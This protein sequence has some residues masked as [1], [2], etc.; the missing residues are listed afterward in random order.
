MSA[1]V[2]TID[3]TSLEE[4]LGGAV[5]LPN[6]GS[7]DKAREIWNA[8][9][10]R[11][12]QAIVRCVGVSDVITAVQFARR[13]DIEVAI[14]SG[15]HSYPGHSTV[16]GGMIID[17]SSMKGIQIDPDQRIA[18]IQPGVLLN[19]VDRETSAFGLALP[20][21]V[22]SGTGLAGLALGG[23][24]GRLTRE[25]G[26]TCDN[27]V[28]LDVVT[29]EGNLVH[30][31]PV[32][33]PDLFWGLRGG[34]GNFGIVVNFEVRLH[35]VGEV[36][37]GLIYYSMEQAPEVMRIARKFSTAGPRKMCNTFIMG[38]RA[39]FALTPV[40]A[41]PGDWMLALYVFFHG[42]MPEARRALSELDHIPSA[43]DCVETKTYEQAQH[44]FDWNN[45]YGNGWYMKSI[46]TR[47][48]SDELIDR[49]LDASTKHGSDLALMSLFSHGGAI[50]DT[51]EEDSAYSGRETAWFL[52]LEVHFATPE[53]R[54]HIV[55]WS[56]ETYDDVAPLF[57][58]DTSYVNFLDD[59]DGKGLQQVYG[60]QKFARLREVKT[61]WDPTNFF[62]H[63]SNIP[64][65]ES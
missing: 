29:A 18:R 48:V 8:D 21:G 65:Y 36:Q 64:P 15:G 55:A 46:E 30:A 57:D 17:L 35:Q 16:D 22:V 7:Y 53:E 51:A 44:E 56:K 3:W 37:S 43:G 38:T 49:L 34:G 54:R 62:R 28:K 39:A 61:K 25:F 13:N 11:R 19:D 60:E 5:I 24:F 63:N 50:S 52:G 45:E 10:D 33:N 59:T 41:D 6:D 2:K 4:T 26:L 14:K 20:A 31:S 47:E 27:F 32:E 12:P 42:S 23:G 9:F 40:E 1:P 58:L